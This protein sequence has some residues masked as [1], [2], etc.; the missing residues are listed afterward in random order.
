MR[1]IKNQNERKKASL[2]HCT[3]NN[4]TRFSEQPITGVG[5][6]FLGDQLGSNQGD[7]SDEYGSTMLSVSFLNKL[8][9]AKKE[10]E[11]RF[12]EM[13]RASIDRCLGLF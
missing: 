8:S 6:F 3:M 2:A 12:F 1:K 11:K 9:G 7:Q 5:S 10:R 13:K 4:S